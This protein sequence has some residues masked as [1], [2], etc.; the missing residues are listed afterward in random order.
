MYDRR[1]IV[2]GILAFAL[3][4]SSP[5]WGGLLS[6]HY[7]RPALALPPGA[8]ACVE[9][10]DFMR[11]GHMRLLNEWRDAALRDGRRQ[12]TAGDGG[13]WTVSLQ[14]TCLSCHADKAAFC[15]VCHASNSV[16]PYCWTCHIAPR[17]NAA[18]GG[19]Q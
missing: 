15:D 6:Q 4:F 12:Y 5:F 7:T 18:P 19:Q 10:R 2:P 3:F 1:F 9:T 16:D 8:T 17:K 11:A 14:N 13:I